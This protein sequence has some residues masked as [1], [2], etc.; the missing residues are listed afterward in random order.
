MFWGVRDWSRG[1]DKPCPFLHN[2]DRIWGPNRSFKITGR[3][4]STSAITSPAVSYISYIKAQKW[5]ITFEMPKETNL[6]P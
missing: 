2:V 1:Q 6:T 3:F 5:A 4:T